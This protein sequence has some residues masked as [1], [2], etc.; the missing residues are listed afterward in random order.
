MFP[1]S[2]YLKAMQD[3]NYSPDT[4]DLILETTA[5]CKNPP[6]IIEEAITIIEASAT[7]Q[8]ALERIQARFGKPNETP[9]FKREI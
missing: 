2:K 9:N 7:E 5:R 3:R 1:L 6:R 4:T 8:E